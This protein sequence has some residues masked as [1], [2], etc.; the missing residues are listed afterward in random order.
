M[1]GG[2][3]HLIVGAVCALLVVQADKADRL[4]SPTYATLAAGVCLP[5]L[6]GFA[7]VSLVAAKAAIGSLLPA[8]VPAAGAKRKAAKKGAAVVAEK[9][10]LCKAFS[11]AQAAIGERMLI[12]G[13]TL[14][15]VLAGH[16]AAATA[17]LVAIEA[18]GKSLLDVVIADKKAMYL[19]SP[20][21]MGFAASADEL[22][23]LCAW[24]FR[25][26]ALLSD[27][28]ILTSIAA[29]LTGTL[30]GASAQAALPAAVFAPFPAGSTGGLLVRAALFR[31]P[32]SYALSAC[33]GAA[34]R[35][36]SGASTFVRLHAVLGVT[37]AL[38]YTER[39]AYL[40]AVGATNTAFSSVAG[41]AL[42]TLYPLQAAVCALA[43]G[44]HLAGSLRS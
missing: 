6:F 26:C 32:V 7:T 4:S 36:R 43:L 30:F 28:I 25:A 14:V 29:P 19:A 42:T 41:A 13:P 20:A 3:L 39:A 38:L 40:A 16:I 11:A 21:D 1:Q 22:D 23:K 44:R 33:S 18:H 10:G 9:T 37:A 24:G 35:G 12:S 8:P 17:G 2:T 15:R 27:V 31:L 5:A 34:A